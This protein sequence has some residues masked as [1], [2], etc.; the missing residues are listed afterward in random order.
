[1]VT[2]LRK[3][4]SSEIALAICTGLRR[5]ENANIC[6]FQVNVLYRVFFGMWRFSNWIPTINVR[7]AQCAWR[8][9][10]T[11]CIQTHLGRKIYNKNGIFNQENREFPRNWLN[12]RISTIFQ[13]FQWVKRFHL[14]KERHCSKAS[15]RN[16]PEG[17]TNKRGQLSINSGFIKIIKPFFFLE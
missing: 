14:R 3:N 13:R 16:G 5:M 6:L 8:R 15:S 7:I 4:T 17:S 9:W 12:W 1:M 2:T 10:T 11:Y